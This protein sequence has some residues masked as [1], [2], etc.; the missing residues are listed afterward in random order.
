MKIQS[1]YYNDTLN[2]FVIVTMT[3]KGLT[4]EGKYVKADPADLESSLKF[5]AQ[6]DTILVGYL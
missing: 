2:Q 3:D 1:V 6:E 5:L 4:V